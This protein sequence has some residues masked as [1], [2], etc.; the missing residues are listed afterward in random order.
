MSEWTVAVADLEELAD[1]ARR[2]ARGLFPGAVVGLIGPL[3]SGKT[4]LVQAL[5]A[6]LEV[7]DPSAVTSPTFIL[8]QE[9]VGRLPIYHFDVYRLTS[10]RQFLDLGAAEI[11]EGP[12]V[13]FIEWADRVLAQLPRD[14]LLVFLEIDPAGGRRLHFQAEGPRHEPL[15]QSLPAAA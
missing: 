8:L 1:L 12:G 3:G 10:P 11:M 15:V 2:L 14:R 13:T 5:A 9:Y 7:P 4:T 6:A